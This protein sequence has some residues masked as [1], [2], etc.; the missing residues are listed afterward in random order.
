MGRLPM[1]LASAHGRVAEAI[2]ERRADVVNVADQVEA[3]S[4]A[5]GDP[6]AKVCGGG[7]AEEQHGA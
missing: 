2:A 6:N 4:Q 1:T 5:E 3:S 7:R